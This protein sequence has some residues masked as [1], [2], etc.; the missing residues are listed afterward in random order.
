MHPTM[1]MAAVERAVRRRRFRYSNEADLQ[2]GLAQAFEAD[3]LAFEREVNIRSDEKAE[4]VEPGAIGDAVARAQKLLDNAKADRVDFLVGESVAV[5]VKIDG[6]L[7]DATRQL[8]RYAQSNRVQGL[9]LV[10]SRNR[11]DNLPRS[12]NGK[13]LRVVTLAGGLL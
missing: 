10:S 12:L 1:L 7:G 9:V 6:S 11:L 4:P 2:R 5:E 3:G 8:H 13:P